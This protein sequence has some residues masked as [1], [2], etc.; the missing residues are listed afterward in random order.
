MIHQDPSLFEHFSAAENVFID[1]KPLLNQSLKI[2]DYN[3]M[4]SNCQKLFDH[5]HFPIDCKTLVKNMG[6]AKKQLVEIAKACVSNARILIMDEPTSA[7]TDTEVSML[8]HI[9]EELKK[10]GISIIYITHRFQEVKE[11]GDRI[12]VLRDG[13]IIGTQTISTINTENI[14]HMMTGLE[15]KERYPKLN[16]K[17]GKELLR[18]SNL[19]SEEIIS[20]INFTLHKKEV[21][22]ITGLVGS[23]RTKIAKCLFGMDSIDQGHITFNNKQLLFHSPAEAIEAGFAYITEDRNAEGL[24]TELQIAKNMIA[25]SMKQISHQSIIT[26]KMEKSIITRFIDRLGIKPANLKTKVE[27]LSGG[28]QQ[29]VLLGRWIM[30]KSKIFILDE[31]TKGMDIPSKIDVYNVM[32]EL[33]SKGASI[34]LISS[35]INEILGMSD[36][37]LVLYGGKIAAEMDRHEASYEKIMYYATIGQ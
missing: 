23:G 34:I 15:L 8:F 25:A 26:P 7:L 17:I 19:C 24:F 35:D 21:L 22:G 31:P 13:E 29:K 20:D 36:R 32:N 1:N 12:T 6:S 10:S 27:H 9:I 11:I 33:V 3:K 30:S 5:F 2:I 37:I 4:Y 28:N 18:V 14:I 16:V